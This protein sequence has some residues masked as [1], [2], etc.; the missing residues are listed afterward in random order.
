[1]LQFSARRAPAIAAFVALAV[2]VG[3]C[4]HVHESSHTT[5]SNPL[6]SQSAAQQVITA[7]VNNIYGNGLLPLKPAQAEC[8]QCVVQA[9]A[10]LGFRVDN[11]ETASA[12]IAGVGL[13]ANQDT[14]LN[15][16]CN[17]SDAAF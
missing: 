16:A 17:Q 3:G 12:L 4:T 1:M 7:C 2:A 13:T 15:N 11:G 14:E 8:K 10:Q 5:T 6:T 9:L